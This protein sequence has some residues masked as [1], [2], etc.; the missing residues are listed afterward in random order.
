VGRVTSTQTKEASNLFSLCQGQ[1][2]KKDF[3]SD[4]NQ[5]MISAH[6]DSL[7]P[8]SFCCSCVGAQV[9]HHPSKPWAIPTLPPIL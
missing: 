7:Y 6:S 9:H 1:A 5:V 8:V 3:V 2:E 4:K